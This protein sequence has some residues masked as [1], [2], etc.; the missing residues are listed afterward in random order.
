[1]KKLLAFILFSS[2]C[3]AQ[4]PNLFY[5]TLI[6]T[7]TSTDTTVTFKTTDTTFA[8][9]GTGYYA[10]IW[11]TKKATPAD[12]YKAGVAEI[13]LINSRTANR[14]DIERAQ[15]GTTAINCNTSGHIYQI[16]VGTYIENPILGAKRF[17][18]AIRVESLNVG[19]ISSLGQ[20]KLFE[21]NLTNIDSNKT[22]GLNA[23]WSSYASSQSMTGNGNKLGSV[24][25]NIRKVGVPTGT[26]KAKLYLA[27]GAYNSGVIV[28]TGSALDSSESMYAI[29]L[30]T[31]Y[32]QTKFTFLNQVSL[33]NAQQY[34]VVL[35]YPTGWDGSNYIQIGY[36]AFGSYAGNIASK[37]TVNGAWSA[38]SAINF[39]FIAYR[40]GGS[41]SFVTA[42]GSDRTVTIPNYSGTLLYN[43]S[44]TSAFATNLTRKVIYISGATPANKYVVTPR[45][46]NQGIASEVL[47]V[48][49]DLMMAIAKTDS[50]IFLR[51]AG[52]TSG[53]KFQY[54]R[55]R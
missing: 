53:L 24:D 50:V 27:S 6:S 14:F 1:M 8:G 20:L 54:Q 28:P 23:N 39:F 43:E 49:G 51:G 44:D 10:T 46:N 48:V 32:V 4:A 30:T 47:P 36:V 12:A 42:T 17:N 11:D 35:E 9:S 21:S 45:G 34:C 29:S 18:N 2:L 31:S 26:I 33:T 55:I 41:S 16:S 22:S 3:L 40:V 5:S 38:N 15:L 19:S 7:I 13:V 25:F 52:T 37:S